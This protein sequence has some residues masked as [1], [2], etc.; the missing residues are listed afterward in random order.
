M[1]RFVLQVKRV[2]QRRRQRQ[3]SKR[4]KGL[5]GEMTDYVVNVPLQD[6]VEQ[7][8]FVE[9][10]DAFSETTASAEGLGEDAF[11]MVRT[12]IQDGAVRKTVI[13]QERDAAERF[14]ALWDD[15]ARRTA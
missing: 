15:A 10:M 1:A 3:S 6:A 8:R 9:V 2:D 7:T 14:V 5:G 4:Q 12:E 11:V 13:F